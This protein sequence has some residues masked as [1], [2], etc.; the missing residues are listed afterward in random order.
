MSSKQYNAKD[1]GLVTITKRKGQRSVRIKI[2]GSKVVVT[3]P[4]W[5]PF[6]AGETFLESR[7]AW[8]LEHKTERSVIG[9]GYVVSNQ[10]VVELNELSHKPR[11][12]KVAGGTLVINVPD[13]SDYSDYIERQVKKYRRS[14]AERLLPA[15]VEELAD[16]FGFSYKSVSVRVLK[17]RWGS[18][19][20][21]KELVFNQNLVALDPLHI[22]YVILHELTHTVHMNHSSEFW[23][24]LESVF[25]NAKRVAKVVRR[26][27]V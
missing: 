3:Q 20:S 16:M 26:I 15:R 2:D 23:Q 12:T 4:Y 17:R 13:A 18:C 9:S 1:I 14:E 27:N 6:S 25:P 19:N 21:H 8:V 24:H 10:L 7:K 11:S 5:L 22:D